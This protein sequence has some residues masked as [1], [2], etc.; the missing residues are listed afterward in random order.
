MAK[1]VD[2]CPSLMV[3]EEIFK[4]SSGEEF[5]AEDEVET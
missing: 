3:R 5:D 1:G 4:C 2:V